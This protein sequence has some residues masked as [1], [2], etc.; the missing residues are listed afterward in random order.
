MEGTSFNI[1]LYVYYVVDGNVYF[2][3]VE[4]SRNV[5]CLNYYPG[6][7]SILILLIPDQYL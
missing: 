6:A 1:C 2:E 4:F 7:T 3:I 5:E